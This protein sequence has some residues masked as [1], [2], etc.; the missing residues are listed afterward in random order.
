VAAGSRAAVC[1]AIAAAILIGP[2]SGAGVDVLLLFIG[3]IGTS[4]PLMAILLLLDRARPRWQVPV[5]A[6]LG[7]SWVMVADK[8]V[9]LTAAGPLIL[10]GAAGIPPADTTSSR[11]ASRSPRPGSTCRASSQPGG[12]CSGCSAPATTG[13]RG[14]PC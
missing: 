14:R 6:G 5:L 11:S 12:T 8:A 3:H 7:L 2:Q 10:V 9:L 4:V 1:A 13:S